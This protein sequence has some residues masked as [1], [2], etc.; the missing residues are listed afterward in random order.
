MIIPHPSPKSLS[1]FS[2]LPSLICFGKSGES[3]FLDYKS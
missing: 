2:A 1:L 3:S